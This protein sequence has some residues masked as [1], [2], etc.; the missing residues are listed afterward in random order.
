MSPAPKLTSHEKR[1]A[2]IATDV[3]AATAVDGFTLTVDSAPFGKQRPRFNS[4]T[5]GARTPKET[6]REE[7]RIVATWRLCGRPRIDGKVPL[8]ADVYAYLARPAAHYRKDGAFTA[9]GVREPFPLRKPD[10]DNVRKLALDALSGRAFVDD[11]YIID[12]ATSKRWAEPG[13]QPR[14]RIEMRQIPTP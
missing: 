8:R 6:L 3:A 10:E 9:Q 7:Q 2:E 12:G 14:V 13:T 4:H 11:A 5:K 1:K